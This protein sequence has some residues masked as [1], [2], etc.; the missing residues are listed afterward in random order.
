MRAG[1]TPTTARINKP[2]V[3]LT[4]VRLGFTPLRGR[5]A[6]GS[7]GKPGRGR[8][9]RHRPL[10][11]EVSVG[12][13]GDVLLYCALPTEAVR[14][15][16][17]FTLTERRS[18]RLV[19]ATDAP[20][21]RGRMVHIRVRYAPPAAH[22]VVRR[23][24]AQ[25][26]KRAYGRPESSGQIVHAP[27]VEAAVGGRLRLCPLQGPNAVGWLCPTPAAKAEA[28]RVLTGRLT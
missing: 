6:V 9:Q 20:E 27:L 21:P 4:L 13:E 5:S 12:N 23:S 28:L 24:G 26:D 16:A 8:K 25:P 22:S 19:V 1:V 14:L 17:G 11:V 18:Q 7:R 15:Q 10:A 3:A 2:L